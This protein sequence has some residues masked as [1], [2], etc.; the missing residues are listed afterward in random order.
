MGIDKDREAVGEDYVLDK[1]LLSF[2]DRG[3]ERRFEIES[4]IA[5]MN[6]IRAY[7]VGGIFI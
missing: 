7:V 5:S 4:V 6:F 2:R 1:L 3:L